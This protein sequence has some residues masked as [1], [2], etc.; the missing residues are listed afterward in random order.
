MKSQNIFKGRYE[1]NLE[2]FEKHL[3]LVNMEMKILNIN[4]INLFD[5]FT[6]KF[7]Q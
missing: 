7:W 4:S 3:F 5:N 2:F 1:I 6:Y